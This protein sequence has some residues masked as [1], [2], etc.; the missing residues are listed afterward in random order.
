MGKSKELHAD[1]RHLQEAYL[2]DIDMNGGLFEEYQK[3]EKPIQK[4]KKDI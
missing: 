1:Y 3:V 2:A 4:S